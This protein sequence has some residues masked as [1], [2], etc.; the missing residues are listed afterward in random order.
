MEQYLV[1]SIIGPN[2]AGVVNNLANLADESGCFFADSR[3]TVFGNELAAVIL[4]YG[5]WAAI[6]KLET[7][8]T[9]FAEKHELMISSRRTQMPKLEGYAI[10]YMVHV[11][12]IEN[13]HLVPT[14]TNFFN[15]QNINTVELT[16]HRYRAQLTNAPMFSLMMTIHIPADV[17]IADLRE[18]FIIFCED[19][20]LDAILEPEK[21]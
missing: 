5:P 17:K 11:I 18:N 6:A 14:I 10:P 13:S 8:L 1:L 15:Q 7:N 9:P 3:I 21:S 4:V 12:A 2:K 16:T 19:H 20:N